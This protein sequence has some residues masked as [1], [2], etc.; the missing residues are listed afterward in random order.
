MLLYLSIEY[1]DCNRF[2][3]A[4]ILLKQVLA[5]LPNS[6]QA[7]LLQAKLLAFDRNLDASEQEARF[8]LTLDPEYGRAY[9]W[10]A[11]IQ[12][13]KL[14][15]ILLGQDPGRPAAA[16]VTG[17]DHAGNQLT[18][19]AAATFA[20]AVALGV[21]LDDSDRMKYATTLFLA[22]QEAEGIRQGQ[23]ITD[24]R[25]H[26]ILGDRVQYFYTVRGRAQAGQV[27]MSQLQ[28]AAPAKHTPPPVAP[29]I[30]PDLL[31]PWRL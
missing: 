11:R 28:Q 10:L 5:Y 26:A 24:P 9:L 15:R 7:H 19:E 14:D 8:A 29:A 18:H 2:E 23:Q 22:Q 16:L 25:Q 12:C 13:I 27:V 31:T 21:R 20:R 1:L 17:T 30:A 6:A 4:R 3:D